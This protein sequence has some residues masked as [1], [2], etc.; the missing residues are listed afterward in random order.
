[1]E[2]ARRGYGGPVPER[3]VL[4]IPAD[5]RSLRSARL[6]VLDAAAQATMDCDTAD[7]LCLALNEICFAAV[8]HAHQGDRLLVEITVDDGVTV[9]GWV[10]S[11]VR[12]ITT[13]LDAFGGLLLDLAVDEY[14]IEPAAGG[15]HFLLRKRLSA[16][17]RS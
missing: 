4:D 17:A 6:A 5:A 11:N 13:D 9:E 7:D 2:L 16:G 3:L 15:V 14:A 12:P 1:M 10:R 8:A